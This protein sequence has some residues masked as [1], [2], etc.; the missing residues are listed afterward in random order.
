MCDKS[1]EAEQQSPWRECRVNFQCDS[2]HPQLHSQ[3]GTYSKICPN[4][5]NLIQVHFLLSLV[6]QSL[7]SSFNICSDI[8]LLLTT[9]SRAECISSWITSMMT[10]LK[11]LSVV[12]WT[13]F[14]I[15]IG[16]RKGRST[17]KLKSLRNK[18]SNF[19]KIYKKKTSSLTKLKTKKLR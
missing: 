18:R 15:I 4:L 2:F 9:K 10:S 12:F 1:S 8:I 11:I 16:K 19:S 6:Q 17:E 14:S 7:S 3:W 5:Q 13:L